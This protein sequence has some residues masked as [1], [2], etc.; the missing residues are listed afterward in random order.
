VG[1][2]LAAGT[3]V[4]LVDPDEKQVEIFAPNEPPRVLDLNDTLTGGDVIMGFS[5]KVSDIFPD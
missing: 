4:W 5:I 1:A 3:L 2:Y